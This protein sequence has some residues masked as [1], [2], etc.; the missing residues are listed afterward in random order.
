[1]IKQGKNFKMTKVQIAIQRIRAFV[2]KHGANRVYSAF[3]GGKDSQAVL[4]LC[5]E[6]IPTG[7]P[8]IHNGHPGESV[9]PDAG[10][11]C[12]KEPKAENVPRFL[13]MTDLAGQID[14][15]R[16]DEDKFVVFDG[17][18]IHR[19]EMPSY[20]TDKGVFG[21]ACLFPLYD[22][23]EEE[24]FN[25][26]AY[27]DTQTYW[28]SDPKL[29]FE[30]EGP[31][32]GTKTFLCRYPGNEKSLTSCMDMIGKAD[33]MYVVLGNG[34]Y[35]WNSDVTDFLSIFGKDKTVTVEC[36]AAD[37]D[38]ETALQLETKELVMI[39]FVNVEDGGVSAETIDPDLFKN[40]YIKIEIADRNNYQNAITQAQSYSDCGHFVY[41]MPTYPVENPFQYGTDMM[42]YIDDVPEHVK[43]MPP[44]QNLVRIK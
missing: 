30:G 44:A 21:L 9:S 28:V 32:I 14:G 17:V 8:V 34:H 41:L 2:S 42:L 22:W 24:V 10:A 12:V 35:L 40:L 26:L 39:W 43:L 4:K 38:S 20:T 13:A 6:A 27:G 19:S 36:S 23:T 37:F 1:M 33:A 11:L 5:R 15:T 7:I 16:R 18:D 31:M 25:Y 3:S 29:S